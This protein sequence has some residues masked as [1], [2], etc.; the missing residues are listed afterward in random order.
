[1]I[2]NEKKKNKRLKENYETVKDMLAKENQT[3]ETLNEELAKYKGNLTQSSMFKVILNQRFGNH[4]D[5]ICCRH[6]TYSE[7]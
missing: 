3:N 4:T 1:M 7:S 2:K 6:L 5:P